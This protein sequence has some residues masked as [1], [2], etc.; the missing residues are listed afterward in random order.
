MPEFIE[1]G[2]Y[3]F[4]GMTNSPTRIWR[5]HELPDGVTSEVREKVL[6]RISWT[7]DEAGRE[8]KRLRSGRGHI[9]YE[10]SVLRRRPV[11][12]FGATGEEAMAPLSPLIMQRL[13]SGLYFDIVDGGGAIWK[14]VG[15]R[16]EGY[17]LS[18]LG[19]MLT[20]YR[21]DPEYRYG[22]KGRGFDTPD[23]LVSDSGGVRLVVECKAKRMAVEARI[24]RD[25]VSDAATA[26]G[27]IAKGMFQVWRFLSH[28]R[29][30][31][32][33][34]PVTDDCLGMVV[35]AD[36]WLVMGQ[37]LY[38]EVMA[39]ANA[40]ADEKDPEINAEDRRRVPIVLIDDLEYT[41]QHAD[42]ATLFE[43][44][45]ALSEDDTGWNWSLVLGQSD[46]PARA[47][48]FADELRVILPRIF[49]EEG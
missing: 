47:Y 20:N 24:S 9:G 29:R 7:P 10:P 6:A 32:L 37:K 31:L 11:L 21:V 13:T 27:E 14:E 3:L 35:T 18:Y 5:N 42:P 44:L 30:G 49:A 2:F 39:I 16:F 28:A 17:C 22:P 25:P 8:A 48:P 15:H 41:L 26:Y 40:L 45:L 12:L 23:I 43:R 19:A 1:A 34:Q 36:P 38:P 46:G 4:A 33:N